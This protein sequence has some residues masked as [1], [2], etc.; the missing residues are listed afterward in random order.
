MIHLYD[1][2]GLGVEMNYHH[3]RE[4]LAGGEEWWE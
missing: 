3:V 1:R 2:P 4:N